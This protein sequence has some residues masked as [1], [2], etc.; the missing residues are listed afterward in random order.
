[1]AGVN[2]TPDEPIPVTI[3]G[4]QVGNATMDDSGT[5]TLHVDRR[6]AVQLWGK[7]IKPSLSISIK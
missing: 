7:E 6:V 3:N 5:I 4:E 2:F 1:M